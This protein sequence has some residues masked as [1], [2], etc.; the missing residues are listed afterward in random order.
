MAIRL[1]TEAV[2][3]LV[4]YFMKRHS[5]ALPASERWD[6]PVDAYS[7]LDFASPQSRVVWA[8]PYPL[9]TRLKRVG[10]N[11]QTLWWEELDRL[12]SMTRAHPPWVR[13]ASLAQPDPL[14]NVLRDGLG[15]GCGCARLGFSRVRC[16]IS[17]FNTYIAI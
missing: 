4:S 13:S 15:K 7:R 10:K 8:W 11:V 2:F 6:Y 16:W 12:H 9:P 17:Y 14:P 3:R 5:L 1:L